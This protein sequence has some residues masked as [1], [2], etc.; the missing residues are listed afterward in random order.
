MHYPHF[1]KPSVLKDVNV[2]SSSSSESLFK[3]VTAP[4]DGSDALFFP[5]PDFFET[6]ET[7]TIEKVLRRLINYE[8]SFLQVDTVNGAEQISVKHLYHMDRSI[9]GRQIIFALPGRMETP[10]KDKLMDMALAAGWH[11]MTINEQSFGFNS[12]TKF[13]MTRKFK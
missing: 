9:S 7:L 8:T 11:S 5:V 4:V 1:D 12:Y 13:Y 3:T 6:F 2:T 10:D